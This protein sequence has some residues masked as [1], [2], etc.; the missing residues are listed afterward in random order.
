MTKVT[1][2]LKIA[3][4]AYD[5]FLSNEFVGNYEQITFD[6]D[7][8]FWMGGTG[9]RAKAYYSSE[10]NTL[11]L[12]Y[13]GTND[14]LDLMTDVQLAV[15]GTSNQD[16]QASQFAQ[17]TKSKLRSMGVADF[18][19]VYTG[20][21][22]GGFLAQIVAT[23]DDNAKAVVFNS[24]GI[25]GALGRGLENP[26]ITYVYSNPSSWR[27]EG[28]GTLTHQIHNIGDL[29]SNDVRFLM[30]A[31]GHSRQSLIDAFDRGE[32]PVLATD[33]REFLREQII[34]E[35][36]TLLDFNS[37]HNLGG[38]VISSVL[39]GVSHDLE[40]F[41]DPQ[42][43]DFLVERRMREALAPKLPIDQKQTIPPITYSRNSA[44]KKAGIGTQ[45]EKDDLDGLITLQRKTDQSAA[46]LQRK[47][48]FGR[49]N[50]TDA[51]VTAERQSVGLE[52][53]M[54]LD[55]DL[56]PDGVGKGFDRRRSQ[57]ESANG[58]NDEQAPVEPPIPRPRPKLNPITEGY[59][60]EMPDDGRL[61]LA[62][63]MVGFNGRKEADK[64][65]AARMARFDVQRKQKRDLEDIKVGK[66]ST[67]WDRYGHPKAVRDLLGDEAYQSFVDDRLEAGVISNATAGLHLLQDAELFGIADGTTTLEAPHEKLAELMTPKVLAAAAERAR[68]ILDMRRTKPSEAVLLSSD[69]SNRKAQFDAAFDA[70]EAV[71][72]EEMDAFLFYHEAA[73]REIGIAEPAI[74]MIPPRW[75]SQVAARFETPQAG[76]GTPTDRR[77]RE[78]ELKQ[79]YTELQQSF[80]PRADDVIAYSLARTASNGAL[81]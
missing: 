14:K 42:G 65:E 31:Q 64:A 23:Q 75:A 3:D 9:F 37:L 41:F 38:V 22:L 35:K 54:G 61:I 62:A 60:K 29:A 16:V 73:Q 6:Q 36:L 1:D 45:L 71:D 79:H 27:G 24:P 4:N 46:G 13:A 10:N 66:V 80:G 30:G 67:V 20:H 53:A 47:T 51:L 11:V 26:N 19:V 15:K 52:A 49:I 40:E 7:S 78:V 74:E 28:A 50:E 32:A 17:E 2:L 8:N 21:S 33:W 34:D 76:N 63:E 25:G 81:P 56:L 68:D 18:N 72:A 48:A 43:T 55:I 57:I 59:L 77:A 44:V 12:A 39:D 58:T 5:P 70:N 69:L